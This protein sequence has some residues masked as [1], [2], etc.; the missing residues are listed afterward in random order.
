MDDERMEENSSKRIMV[1]DFRIEIFWGISVWIV[2]IKTGE[3]VRVDLANLYGVRIF[4]G[5]QEI[6]VVGEFRGGA[7]R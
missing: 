1:G 2:N 6:V 7:R 5:P 3:A 4:K